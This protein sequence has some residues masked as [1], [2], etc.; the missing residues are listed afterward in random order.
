MSDYKK[1]AD[2]ANL[3]FTVSEELLEF[4][5]NLG[6]KNDVTWIPNGIDFDHAFVGGPGLSHAIWDKKKICKAD[7]VFGCQYNGYS[8]IR[9]IIHKL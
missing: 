8:G 4:Y 7:R 9:E 1:I 5:K 3:I 6:R 2:E